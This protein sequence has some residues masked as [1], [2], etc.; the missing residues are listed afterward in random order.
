[1]DG[2]SEAAL[3]TV[4]RQYASIHAGTTLDARF[5]PINQFVFDQS[6]TDDLAVTADRFHILDPGAGRQLRAADIDL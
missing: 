4:L 3:A 1:M 5:R 2:R 6:H